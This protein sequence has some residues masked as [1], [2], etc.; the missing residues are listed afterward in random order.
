MLVTERIESCSVADSNGCWIWARSVDRDGYGRFKIAGR[1]MRAHRVSYEAFVGSAAGRLVCHKC[2][3][4]S[5]VNPDH[6][7][8]GTHST[9]MLDRTERN[10]VV[11]RGKK[12]GPKLTPVEFL[13]IKELRKSGVGIVPLG[14]MFGV[15]KNR[16]S[17]ICNHWNPC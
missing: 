4:P 15:T 8:L 13:R 10:R 2:D 5:C 3:V 12:A 1:T 9:N 16:I 17:Q 14:V 7:V 11:P 6:L